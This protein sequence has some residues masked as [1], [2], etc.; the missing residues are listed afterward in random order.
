[1]YSTKNTDGKE[2]N[3][4][5][6][7]NIAIE[8]SEFTDVLFNK[9]IVTHKMRRSQSKKHKGRTYKINKITLSCF[10]DKRFVLDDSIHTLAYFHKDLKKKLIFTNNHKK[11]FMKKRFSQMKI[12]L[13]KYILDNLYF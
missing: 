9:E 5:K 12:D 1:M 4:A 10:D 3:M 2:S 13:H 8:L 6:G 7:V 11:I